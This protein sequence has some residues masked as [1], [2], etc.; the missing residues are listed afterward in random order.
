MKKL[1]ALLLAVCMVFGL[2]APVAATETDDAM[3]A[4]M[5]TMKKNYIEFICGTVENNS[6]EAVASTTKLTTVI[7]NAVTAKNALIVD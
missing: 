7:N 1:F 6:S 2:M 3:L 4:Q 5:D